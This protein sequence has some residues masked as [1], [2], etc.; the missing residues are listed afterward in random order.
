MHFFIIHTFHELFKTPQMT[1]ET[2]TC[3][4]AL[5]HLQQEKQMYLESYWHLDSTE[6]WDAYNDYYFIKGIK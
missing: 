4:T 5:A 2:D 1:F 3:P 6:L